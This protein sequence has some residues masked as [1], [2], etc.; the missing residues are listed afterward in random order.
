M[1]SANNIQE[2]LPTRLKH[3]GKTRPWRAPYKMFYSISSSHDELET[4]LAERSELVKLQSISKSLL[5]EVLSLLELICPLWNK[6]EVGN[7][8][9]LQYCAVVGHILMRKSQHHKSRLCTQDL[10]NSG[11]NL[12]QDKG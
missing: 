11:S 12:S 2:H 6:L 7:L 4:I 10:G 8:P 3:G 5:T 9:S 1:K